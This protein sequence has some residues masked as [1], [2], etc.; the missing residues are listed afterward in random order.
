M[1]AVMSTLA[2]SKSGPGV[3]CEHGYSQPAGSTHHSGQEHLLYIGPH[4]ADVAIPILAVRGDL[5]V[6]RLWGCRGTNQVCEK[7]TGGPCRRLDSRRFVGKIKQRS[8]HIW[9][10]RRT[11][12]PDRA[13]SSVTCIQY[14]A[15]ETAAKAD[16]V[17]AVYSSSFMK[18]PELLEEHE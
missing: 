7:K 13:L 3:S 1:I 18:S 15:R 16:A 4:V 5:D 10:K 14:I 17:A 12:R 2:G 8:V 6:G 9:K 11:V